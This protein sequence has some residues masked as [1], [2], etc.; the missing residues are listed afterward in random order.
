MQAFSLGLNVRLYLP[1]I[2][3]LQPIQVVLPVA[4]AVHQFLY[5]FVVFRLAIRHLFV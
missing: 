1:I 5:Q 3:K 4:G 2:I